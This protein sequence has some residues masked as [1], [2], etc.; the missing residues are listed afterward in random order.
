MT[1]II[2]HDSQKQQFSVV[3]DKLK[4][5]LD[6]SYENEKQAL[7]YYHTYVPPALRGRKIAEEIV[8]FALRYAKEQ[9]LKVIPSCL[10][11]KRFLDKHPEFQS[12]L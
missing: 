12:L 2:H 6:Y 7:N 11:V 1:L 5:Y 3:V 10:Y 9:N 8:T 4:C